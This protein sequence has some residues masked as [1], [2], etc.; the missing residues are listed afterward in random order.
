MAL[1]V[2][3]RSPT[4]GTLAMRA[5]ISTR[6][7]RSVGSPPVRRNLRKPTATAA[8]TTCSI[9][10]AVSRSGAGRKRRPVSGMQYTQRRLQW[11]VSESRK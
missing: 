4:P 7:A 2:I 9:S 6:S 11:S 3:D 10:A 1:V 5:T 8:R